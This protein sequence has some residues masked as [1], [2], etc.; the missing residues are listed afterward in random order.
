MNTVKDECRLSDDRETKEVERARELSCE[1]IFLSTEDCKELV[2]LQ[3]NAKPKD[4]ANVYFS[5]AKTATPRH[6]ARIYHRLRW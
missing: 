3:M 1:T 6:C 2:G 4:G 5:A